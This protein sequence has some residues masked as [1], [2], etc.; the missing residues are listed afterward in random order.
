MDL[1]QKLLQMIAVEIA[2]AEKESKQLEKDNQGVN[3][4]IELF[5]ILSA[6]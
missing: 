4:V 2:M 5:D 1:E 3:A 6:A